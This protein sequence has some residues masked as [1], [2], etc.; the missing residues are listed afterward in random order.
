MT[1]FPPLKAPPKIKPA[2]TSPA[3]PITRRAVGTEPAFVNVVKVIVLPETSYFIELFVL[4]FDPTVAV[5]PNIIPEVASPAKPNLYG[6]DC[7][8][9]LVKAEKLKLFP[10]T[11]YL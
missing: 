9:D 3:I 6:I 2:V 5:P 7:E 10:E 1:L 11:V 8:P 4:V